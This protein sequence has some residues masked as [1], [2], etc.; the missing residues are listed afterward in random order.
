MSIKARFKRLH[1][2]Q[3]YLHKSQIP[4]KAISGIRRQ[5]I[6]YVIEDMIERGMNVFWNV[7]SIQFLEV[8]GD[9]LCDE[10]CENQSQ[11]HEL[12]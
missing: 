12:L 2:I 9:S 5:E 6:T 11:N 7:G 8:G 3:L 1:I 4:Q 10:L